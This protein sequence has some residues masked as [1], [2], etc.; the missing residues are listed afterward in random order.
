MFKSSSPVSF[1]S[2][3]WTKFGIFILL[4]F[5]IVLNKHIVKVSSA[6]TSEGIQKIDQV[7]D[8][9]SPNNNRASS[10][11]SFSHSSKMRQIEIKQ[12]KTHP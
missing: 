4:G 10:S 12:R 7:R 8:V 1:Q 5:H 3:H 9:L 6:Q 11:V 2:F